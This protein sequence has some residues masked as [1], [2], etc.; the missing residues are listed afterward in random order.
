MKRGFTFVGGHPLL[1]FC[2]TIFIHTDS[3]LDL[4]ESRT[5]IERWGKEFSHRHKILN[6]QLDF[7]LEAAHQIR[8]I[9]RN[10]FESVILNKPMATPIKKLNNLFHNHPIS[11]HLQFVKNLEADFIPGQFSNDGISW[12][13]IQ[14]QDFLSI[15]KPERLK[16]CS[17]PN[18]SHIF[19]DT[20]KSSTRSWC[21]M[22]SCGNIMKARN[23]RKARKS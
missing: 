5:D 6:I 23:F 17:N 10:L 2:N 9:L 12:I 11:V 19:Y 8:S 13:Q 22:K 14:L 20:S 1:D 21:S 16:I 4:F 18:C 3:T 15:C 7:S